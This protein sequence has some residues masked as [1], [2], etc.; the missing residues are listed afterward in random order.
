[1]EICHQTVTHLKRKP[2]VNEYI[3][4]A[5]PRL[6]RTRP[7]RGLDQAQRCRA[8]RD[9]TPSGR[10]RRRNFSR[11]SRAYPTPFGMH[12]MLH[13]IVDLNRQEGPSP[14]MEGHE[15]HAHPDVFQFC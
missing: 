6:D 11:R 9:Y 8:H 15:T 5:L 4:G 14:H 2:R 10:L 1:M 3:R 7:R 12:L 13:Y